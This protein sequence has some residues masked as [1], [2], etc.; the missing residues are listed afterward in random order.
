M[1]ITKQCLR[2][3]VSV[4][5]LL[6]AITSFNPVPARAEWGRPYINEFS[7]YSTDDDWVEIYNPH[8]YALYTSG[9]TLRD[10]TSSNVRT[11]PDTIE[12]GRFIIFAF[13]DS[14]NRTGDTIRII[15]HNNQV[16]ESITYSNTQ[17]APIKAS[18]LGKTTSK[19][20]DQGS[21]WEESFSTKYVSNS[22]PTATLA[23]I[24]PNT[25]QSA[26]RP[27]EN[28]IRVRIYYD[29]INLFAQ[30]RLTLTEVGSFSI[31]RSDCMSQGNSSS[32]ICA[33]S[34]SK[35]WEHLA[36]GVYAGGEASIYDIH[37]NLIDTMAIPGFVV[38]NEK[39]TVTS[40]LQPEIN[41]L[42]DTV[43]FVASA[44]DD[45]ALRAI[46]VSIHP[47][48][49]DGGCANQN[50]MITRL[51]QVA[52]A[53]EPTSLQLNSNQLAPGNYCALYHA[54]DTARNNSNPNLSKTTFTVH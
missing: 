36:P 28:P 11:F 40:Y 17:S 51:T 6:V 12:G 42:T 9:W 1:N 3:L 10:S 44:T 31:E 46:N 38:D 34:D 5:V 8:T 47:T 16:V 14:L 13:G 50:Y 30:L 26:T 43:S 15:N 22:R 2:I 52:G 27:G 37:E 45:N 53:H 21:I 48:R 41:H 33:A 4:S 20:N 19:K 49:A 23:P 7:S 29:H 54:T 18:I 24:L 35:T 32:I 39:P 25:Q